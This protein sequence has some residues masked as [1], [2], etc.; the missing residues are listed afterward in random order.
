[1]IEHWL[2]LKRNVPSFHFISFH[3]S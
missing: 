3:L 1:M 2:F